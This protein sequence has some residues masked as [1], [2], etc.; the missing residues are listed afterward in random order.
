MQKY[1]Y[2]VLQSLQCKTIY[3]YN[4]SLLVISVFLN[5]SGTLSYDHLINMV[6]S[7]PLSLFFPAKCP[8]FFL[9]A[10]PGNAATL[11]IWTPH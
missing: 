2:N 4:K 10:K 11:M 1:S 6:S 5:Y 8:Q 3:T 7:L 9:Y